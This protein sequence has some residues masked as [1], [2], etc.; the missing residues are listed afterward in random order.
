MFYASV[1]AVPKPMESITNYNV[2]L[3]HGAYGKDKGFLGENDS[4]EAYY[5]KTSLENGASLGAY[6]N[7]DRIPR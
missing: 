6:D 2:L 5:A 1:Y 4:N 7:K 3:L